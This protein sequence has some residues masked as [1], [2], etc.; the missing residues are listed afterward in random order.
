ML[1]TMK[2]ILDRASEENYGVAAPNIFSELDCRAFIEAAEAVNAPLIL[3]VAFLIEDKYRL[4]YIARELARASSV[5]IA[6]NLDHGANLTHIYESIQ[7]G[8]TSV[9]IDCSTKPY[10]EAVATVKQVVEACH[11]LGIS[12]E[13]EI[14]HVGEA[15]NYAV[16][17]NAALTTPEMAVDFIEKTGVDCLAV[18][19][20]TAHGIY[21]E[22]VE[23]EIDFEL[24]QAI[25][26]ATN[27]FPLVLHGS[28]GTTDEDLRKACTMGIN[29]L[30]ICGELL[31]AEIEAVKATDFTGNKA[32][33]IYNVMRTAL[34]EKL[35]EKIK[36]YGS[37]NKAWVARPEGI[38]TATAKVEAH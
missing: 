14:G 27:N 30:N 33:D 32:Y 8:F 10:E 13:T 29:K 12:V 18:A 37:E 3:D 38:G 36:V 17:R 26:K 28:S 6:I 31:Q 23:P 24:L 35:I 5:P 19:V 9:M 11:A 15:D 7:A 34:K 1:V 20:G 21:P 2:E 22:G 25:K 4:G 16:D